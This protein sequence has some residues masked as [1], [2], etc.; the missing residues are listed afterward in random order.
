MTSIPSERP[1]V[2]LDVLPLSVFDEHEIHSVVEFGS[3]QTTR[4]IDQVKKPA[5]I[6]SVTSTAPSGTNCLRHV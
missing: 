1:P 6:T 4:L 5:R 2:T 3:G